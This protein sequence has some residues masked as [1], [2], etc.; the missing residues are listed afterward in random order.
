MA[1]SHPNHLAKEKSPYLLQHAYNPV[2]WFPWGKEAFQKAKKENKPI[3]LSIGYSTCHWCHVMERESFENHDVANV[4]NEHFVSIKVDREE[5]PD[6]DKIYM[7]AVQLLGQGGGWPLSV[8]LTPDLKPFFGGTYFPPTNRHGRIGFIELLNKL[9]TVWQQ[10][11]DNVFQSAQEISNHLQRYAASGETSVD[12]INNQPLKLTSEHFRFSY[13]AC[14]G[15]FGSA[16]KFP[17]PVT[18]HFLARYAKHYQ[19][20]EAKT[21]VFHTLT[22]M[23]KG[24][25]YDQ[26]GGGFSRYSVD[27]KWL[28][29][30][31]EKMLYDN[32]QLINSYLDAY[33]L[34][35]DPQL[36]EFFAFVVHDTINY[37][38]RDMSSPAGAFYSAEDADSEGREGAFYVWSPTQIREVLDE[39]EAELAIRFL[40]ITQMGN[41]EDHS[42]PNKNIPSQ[43]VLSQV[44]SLNKEEAQLWP[45]IRKKLLLHREK[46]PRPHRDDKI[47][48]SWNGLLISALARAGAILQETKYI[49]AAIQTANFLQ[50]QQ[51][52]TQSRHL[53]HSYRD[54]V[55]DKKGMLD[56]YVFLAQGLIDLYEATFE[57]KWLDWAN[58]LTET[59]L[60]R[61]EDKKL[62][63]FFM[64]DGQ[65]DSLLIRIKEDY[66]GAE[67]SGNSVAALVLI[68]LGRML[69]RDDFLQSAEK[70]LRFFWS[71]LL[72]IPEAVPHFA[73]AL[74]AW[75]NPPHQL[76][77]SGD[78]KSEIGEKMLREVRKQFLPN[79]FLLHAES[80]P[81]EFKLDKNQVTAYLC[82]DFQCELPIM[83][84][85]TLKKK[86]A[87]L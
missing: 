48:T 72:K 80:A 37:L 22:M 63:G 26:M 45:I 7:T 34:T 55:S 16:P 14:Y 73:S 65:D 31:F 3:F 67:P 36:K 64:T 81:K 39:K 82:H 2:D 57:R 69:Q 12:P 30:H 19:N 46:R 42:A 53:Y 5:R 54:G 79:L 18:L 59:I 41:F 20:E 15:G 58:E 86:I 60:Q 24:G 62:G 27:E 13:D 85:S 50:S 10:E 43:N 23:A 77:F 40:G 47:L 25:I 51:Y 11:H 9:N 52:E 83:D 49:H 76:I 29:P 38:S 74:E 21:M 84:A 4:L 32:A 61:F 56:D 66:D 68:K 70:I 35:E 87:E 71:R 17:R 75:L 6:I 78:L 33:Q 1:H 44:I 8:W 28:V